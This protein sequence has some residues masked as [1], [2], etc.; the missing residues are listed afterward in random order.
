[1]G[2]ILNQK[3]HFEMFNET[4]NIPM[5]EIDCQIITDKRLY[6]KFERALKFQCLFNF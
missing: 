6:S 1:M 2:V 5:T 4:C 3:N